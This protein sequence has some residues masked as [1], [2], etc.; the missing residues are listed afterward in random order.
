M[1]LLTPLARDSQYL[2]QH[3]KGNGFDDFGSPGVVLRS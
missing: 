3:L 2:W 1:L